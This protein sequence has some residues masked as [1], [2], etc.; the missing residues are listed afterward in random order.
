MKDVRRDVAPS[1][2][3]DDIVGTSNRHT[4]EEGFC[5]PFLYFSILTFNSFFN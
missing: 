3:G 2:S 1:S 4:F 5:C